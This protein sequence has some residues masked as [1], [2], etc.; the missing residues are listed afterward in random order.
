[1]PDLVQNH[2]VRETNPSSTITNPMHANTHSELI[3]N[4]TDV[5]EK[6]NSY[7]RH[8]VDQLIRRSEE[9]YSDL[10]HRTGL[11]MLA[12]H[13]S[14]NHFN[15]QAGKIFYDFNFLQTIANGLEFYNIY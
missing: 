2:S 7:R 10:S 6:E 12:Q 8:E 14:H 15:H 4:S 3:H 5:S 11:D 1:M 13:E 9:S